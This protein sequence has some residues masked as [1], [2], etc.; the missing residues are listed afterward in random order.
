MN[1]TTSI[2]MNY[3]NLTLHSG[4]K[5]K[6]NFKFVTGTR[7]NNQTLSAKGRI[8]IFDFLLL[9]FDFFKNKANPGT[10]GNK[11]CFALARPTAAMVDCP[12]RK[13]TVLYEKVEYSM[14]M[15]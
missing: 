10:P 15:Q 8:L 2:T 9:T 6:P 4:R 1:L 11:P 13:S 7:R 14:I 12:N 5:N 3:R